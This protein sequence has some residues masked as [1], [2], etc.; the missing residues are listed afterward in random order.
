MREG[1]P[2]MFYRSLGK[3]YKIFVVKPETLS[4]ITFISKE[5]ALLYNWNHPNSKKELVPYSLEKEKRWDMPSPDPIALEVLRE[6][7]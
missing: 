3:Y 5:G 4:S 6:M 7:K 2:E 1:I